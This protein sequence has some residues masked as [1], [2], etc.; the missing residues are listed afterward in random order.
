MFIEPKERPKFVKEV[1]YNDVIF[2][3]DT[4]SQGHIDSNSEYKRPN[5]KTWVYS[6]ME[7]RDAWMT[8]SFFPIKVNVNKDPF[9]RLRVYE[10]SIIVIKAFDIKGNDFRDFDIVVKNV[11]NNFNIDE[12]LRSEIMDN[13]NEIR[14]KMHGS[15]SSKS[16][17][18]VHIIPEKELEEHGHLKSFSSIIS[19]DRPKFMENEYEQRRNTVVKEETKEYKNVKEINTGKRNIELRLSYLSH[20]NEDLTIDVLG[21]KITLTGCKY[22]DLNELDYDPKEYDCLNISTQT[23]NRIDLLGTLTRPELIRLGHI[24]TEKEEYDALKL[25]DKEAKIKLVE[26]LDKRF[27]EGMV[28]TKFMFEHNVSLHKLFSYII[29]E[30]G[31]LLALEKE[32][33]S[34]AKEFIKL[35]GS[36]K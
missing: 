6:N 24:K 32:E 33:I 16:V 23:G 36:V 20:S 27:E 29:R 12:S 3:S 34:T 14:A 5:V 7:N 28:V 31:A 22:D 18:L 25:K 1:K 17:R 26:S 35:L 15:S 10:R 8:D 9:V 19:L 11:F 30:E 2:E 21:K 13:L 4:F